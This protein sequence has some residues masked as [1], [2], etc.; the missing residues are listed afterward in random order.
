M[1]AKRIR[2]FIINGFSLVLLLSMVNS[3]APVFS[4]LQSART[5][6]KGGVEVTPSYSSVS[7]K[8]EESS[9]AVQNHFGVQAAYGITPKIDL[10][11]RYELI[12]FKD[13]DLRDELG[14]FHI[15]AFGPKV[16]L[17]PDILSLYVPVGG[18][19]NTEDADGSNLELQPTVLLTYPAFKNMLDL[20]LSTKYILF[21][22][23]DSDGG[24]VAVN[25]GLALG[26]DV[27]D[28]AIRPEYGILFKPG[29]DG[30]Y[31]HFSIGITKHFGKKTE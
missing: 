14:S 3:C 22:S 9:E 2:Q 19:L 21:L 24:W 27:R 15:W 28:L 17:V 31:R 16:N 4:D 12:G 23:D 29:E 20:N 13:E 8:V 6:G 11:M 26:K 5:A 10:R 25:L 18:I 7:M 1:T 30:S